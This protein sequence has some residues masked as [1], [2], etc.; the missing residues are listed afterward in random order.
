MK[1]AKDSLPL[2]INKAVYDQKPRLWQQ[3]QIDNSPVNQLF[4]SPH[5]CD[6]RLQIVVDA[7]SRGVLL[8]MKL[9]WCLAG[10]CLDRRLHSRRTTQIEVEKLPVLLLTSHFSFPLFGCISCNKMI[11]QTNTK[12]KVWEERKTIT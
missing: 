6:S 4:L 2:I 11:I 12:I 3:L 7:L 5:I 8:K 10:V 9:T 1:C